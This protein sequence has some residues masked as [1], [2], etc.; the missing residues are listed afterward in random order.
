MILVGDNACEILVLGREN[1]PR[2]LPQSGKLTV[3]QTL[4]L[5]QQ[6]DVVIG[7]ETGVLNAVAF[8]PNAK[9]V[10]LSHSSVENL[11]KHWVNTESLFASTPCYPCHQLHYGNEFCAV[12]QDTRCAWCALS[13]HPADVWE[14]GVGFYERA[15]E[16]VLG[17]AA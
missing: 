14:A 4:A 8:E 5:E 11:T 3:R 16:R 15:R 10:M 12:D 2:V 1:E 6:C 9:V 13:I 7:P 17:V